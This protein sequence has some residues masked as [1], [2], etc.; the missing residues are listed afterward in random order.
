MVAAFHNSG[1][2]GEAFVWRWLGVSPGVVLLAAVLMAI[3]G[4]AVGTWLEKK[5][6]T[7]VNP[8]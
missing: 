8:E 1:D 3:G 5:K 2:L 4:F 6:G 7:V